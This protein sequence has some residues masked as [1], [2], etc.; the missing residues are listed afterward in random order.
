MNQKQLSLVIILAVLAGFLGGMISSQ[1]LVITPVFAQKT[2]NH[3]KM[4]LAEEFALVNQES[5][6]Y[7]KIFITPNDRPAIMLFDKDT[8]TENTFE[9][10][11]NSLTIMNLL[12]WLKQNN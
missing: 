7:A 5:K 4:V 12:P 9:L 1:L 6:L 11:P 3:E 2:A 8:N 10:S